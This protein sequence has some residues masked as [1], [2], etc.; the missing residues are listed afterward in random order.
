MRFCDGGSG[1]GIAF[2]SA[3]SSF[4]RLRVNALRLVMFTV[5]CC[6]DIVSWES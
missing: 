6:V 3:L 1:S 5:P 2:P 4:G